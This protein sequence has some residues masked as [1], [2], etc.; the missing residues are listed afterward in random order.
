MEG[1]S[2]QVAAEMLTVESAVQGP[3]NDDKRLGDVK[4]EIQKTRPQSAKS[5]VICG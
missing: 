3:P 5:L 1:D 4:T 2:Q